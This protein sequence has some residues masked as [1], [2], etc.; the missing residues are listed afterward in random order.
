MLAVG[1]GLAT[2]ELAWIRS[3][4]DIVPADALGRVSSIDAL[5][6]SVLLPIGFVC[7]GLATATYG[8]RLVFFVGGLASAG[9]IGLG[10]LHPSVRGL[11]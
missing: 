9:L 5:G 11:D 7:A 8:A 2:L 1:G 6:S 10:L 4:Q 3:L